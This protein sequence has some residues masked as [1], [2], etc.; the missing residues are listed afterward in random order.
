MLPCCQVRSGCLCPAGSTSSGR[1]LHRVT[2]CVSCLIGWR[3]IRRRFE[4]SFCV[5]YSNVKSICSSVVWLAVAMMELESGYEKSCMLLLPPCELLLELA[6]V[7]PAY[8]AE[9][10]VKFHL[11]PL[12]QVALLGQRLHLS[13]IRCRTVNLSTPRRSRMVPDS[14]FQ[15]S[16]FHCCCSSSFRRRHLS[17]GYINILVCRRSA[18]KRSGFRCTVHHHLQCACWLRLFKQHQSRCGLVSNKLKPEA[19]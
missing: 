18:V 1:Q 8:C 3:R 5:G 9:G 13:S 11:P 10:C 4:R 2:V 12:A 14:K 16:Y 19:C 15:Q 6:T 7:V 17:R